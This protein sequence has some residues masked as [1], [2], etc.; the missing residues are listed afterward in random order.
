MPGERGLP[1]LQGTDGKRVSTII[2]VHRVCP[3]TSCASQCSQSTLMLTLYYSLCDDRKM[4]CCGLYQHTE[5][6]SFRIAVI[7][8]TEG[9]VTCPNL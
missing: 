4:S 5:A 7:N 3:I 2:P 6:I 1:G 8:S 9:Y